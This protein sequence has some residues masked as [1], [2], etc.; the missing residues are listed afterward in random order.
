MNMKKGPFPLLPELKDGES[1]LSSLSN[2]GIWEYKESKTFKEVATSFKYEVSTSYI[3]VCSIPTIWAQPLIFDLAIHDLKFPNRKQLISQWQGFTAAFALASARS[4]PISVQ[5]LDLGEGKNKEKLAKSLFNLLP[6]PTNCL[7]SINNKNPWQVLYTILW[8]GNAVGMTSPSTI[9]APS[10]EGVWDGLPWWQKNNLLSPHKYLNS[11]EKVLLSLWLNNLSDHLNEQLKKEI[12]SLE[13]F[14]N[15]ELNYKR[16][17]LNK[18]SN[19][20]NIIHNLIDDYILSL[21]CSTESVSNITNNGLLNRDN[22]YGC[23]INTGVLK[24]INRPIKLP[25]ISWEQ[26][27]VCLVQTLSNADKPLLLIDKKIARD[28]GVELNSIWVYGDKTLASFDINNT[29]HLSDDVIFIQSKDFFESDLYFINYLNNNTTPCPGVNFPDEIN[30]LIFEDCR[31]LPI[32]PIK[33]II[34]KYIDPEDLFKSIT[35]E[36]FSSND[37]NLIVRVSIELRLSGFDYPKEYK[38][39]RISKDYKIKSDNRIDEVPIIEL[40]PFISKE[41]WKDYYLFYYCRDNNKLSLQID[42]P[43]RASIDRFIEDDSV[44]TKIVVKDYPS[45]LFCT[46]NKGVPIGILFLHK[47]KQTSQKLTWTIG[48]DFGTS[49]TNVYLNKGNN[50]IEKLKYSFAELGLQITTTDPSL[51]FGVLHEHFISTILYTDT[52]IL[53]F[54]SILTVRDSLKEDIDDFCPIIDGRK[55][56]PDASRSFQP[57][58]EWIK[59]GLKWDSSQNI[60]SHLYLKHITLEISALSI[61]HNVSKIIWSI[62]YPTAFSKSEQGNFFSFW[63]FWLISLQEQT[64]INHVLRNWDPNNEIIENKFR[65]ESLAVGQFFKDYKNKRL[66]KTTCMDIGGGTTD[67]SIWENNNIIYQCSIKLAAHDLLHYPLKANSGLLIKLLPIINPEL[68]NTPIPWQENWNK[69]KGTAFDSK[70]DFFLRLCG[71]K[72]LVSQKSKLINDKRFTGLVRLIA[73]GF[74]GLFYYLGLILKSLYKDKIYRLGEITPVYLGGNGSRLIKWL[75]SGGRYYENLDIG[76]LFSRMQSLASEFDDI[77]V[78]TYLSES[79]KDEVAAGLVLMDTMLTGYG[80]DEKAGLVSGENCIINGTNY[81]STSR[82]K[83]GFHS[84]IDTFNVTSFKNLA[85]FLYE[86]DTGVKELNIEEITPFSTENYYDLD[87]SVKSNLELWRDVRD[88][89]QSLV[90]DKRGNNDNIRYEPPFIL[91]LK[92]LIKVLTDRWLD[93]EAYNL[94]NFYSKISDSDPESSEISLPTDIESID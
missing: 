69:L 12:N 35:Y 61:K 84:Q 75:V 85:D 71:D 8:N 90:L 22:F 13:G 62:S 33:K 55:Y 80:L 29:N 42:H 89:F 37:N 4:F 2:F 14:T 19:S 18:I 76:K 65:T 73:L 43:E 28:W 92:A 72:W 6:S 52:D 83:I 11:K 54:S 41:Q 26:S 7:Y 24:G 50:V 10:S 36:L 27:N 64:G 63:E 91:G 86:F 5:Y 23:P 47:P 20:H 39:F 56:V 30:P 17:I 21:N 88:E 16:N 66:S 40:W 44:I 25:S 1:N 31:I 57:Q 94:E 59:T 3:N 79:F 70:L 34:L 81:D 82:I 38:I 51:R 48:L 58:E 93:K 45:Y 9:F 68:I 67:I 53:P 15:D 78:K 32:P 46:C 74:S 77:A 60:Y 49:F 87:P